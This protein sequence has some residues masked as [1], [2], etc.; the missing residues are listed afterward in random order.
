M[1]EREVERERE[2][3]RE[4]E[5]EERERF[6][7]TAFV[8]K[9]SVKNSGGKE[10]FPE[11]NKKFSCCLALTKSSRRCTFGYLSNGLLKLK[12]FSENQAKRLKGPSTEISAFFWSHVGS[13]L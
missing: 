1:K 3:E 12:C 6:E 9:V 7:R 2:K 11:V 4:S 8:V 10:I 5:E 13:C